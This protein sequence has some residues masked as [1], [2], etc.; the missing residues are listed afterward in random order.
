ML[1]TRSYAH[2]TSD[3]PL[4]GDTLGQHFDTIAERWS[5][6]DALVVR[7]QAIRWTWAELK[8]HG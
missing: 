4:L 8:R 2:G 3:V 7:H 6:R 5:D 1:H